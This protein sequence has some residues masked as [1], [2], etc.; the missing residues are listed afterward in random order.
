MGKIKTTLKA[1]ARFLGRLTSRLWRWFRSL[2]PFTQCLLA[3]PVLCGLFLLFTVGN[4]GLAL[5]GTAIALPALF[6]GWLGALI[7]LIV[8]KAGL[9]IWKS[10]NGDK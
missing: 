8:S 9:I 1:T 3:I 6:V 2:A 5:M 7:A 4:M 10:K